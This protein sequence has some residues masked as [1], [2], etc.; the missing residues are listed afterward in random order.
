[1]NIK[2]QAQEVKRAAKSWLFKLQNLNKEQFN[3][4]VC[5]YTGAFIDLQPET[6][7]RLHAQCPR[8][9]ALE[10]HR[11]QYLVIDRLL[12]NLDT[13]NLS[14]MHFAPENFFRDYFAQKFG[15][16]ETAD[17]YM[18]EVDHQVDL[19]NLPFDDGSYDFIFA[20]HVLEHIADD[21][22]AI[23]EIRRILKP[24]GIAVLPVPIFAET[25]VEYPEPNPHEE[26]HVRAPGLDYC[27]RYEAH[28]SKVDKISSDLLP[29]KHQLYVYENRSHWSKD[30]YPLRPIMAGKKFIDIVPVCYV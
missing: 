2:N 8:C 13:A 11:I 19:Q 27:D 10:R 4:P 22:K 16:Y 18:S 17:L 15:N 24:N 14:M 26:Y 12:A 3:C 7:I 21:Q 1:M 5:N 30:K 23:A 29:A 20:S 28:F 6:G 25:T 9:R